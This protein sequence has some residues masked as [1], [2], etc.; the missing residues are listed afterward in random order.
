MFFPTSARHKS[1]CSY[2]TLLSQTVPHPQFSKKILALRQG[3]SED[4]QPPI[5]LVRRNQR[6]GLGGE[7]PV[8][9]RFHSISVVLAFPIMNSKARYASLLFVFGS[10]LATA[11]FA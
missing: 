5:H 8:T 6:A 2:P 4:F 10:V 9:S 7:F 3:Q 1:V 11:L